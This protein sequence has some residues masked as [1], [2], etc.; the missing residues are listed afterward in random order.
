MKM[1]ISGGPAQS[2]STVIGTGG[3]WNRD[4]VIIVGNLYGPLNRISEAGGVATEITNVEISHGEIGHGLPSLLPDGKHFLYFIRGSPEVEGVYAGSL[5][6]KPGEQPRKQI[7]ASLLAAS[8]ANGYLFFMRDNT[9]M[10]QAFDPRAL[11]LQGEPVSLAENV[12]TLLNSGVFSVSPSGVL[13]YHSVTHSGGS[14]FT[15][16]D[17][18][19]RESG[20]LGDRT[21]DTGPVLSPDG[22]RV[23]VRDSDA[24][25]SADLWILDIKRRGMR[26]RV[27]TRQGII[28]PAVWSADGTHVIFAAGNKADG[29][30]ASNVIYEKAS[31]GAVDEKELFRDTKQNMV[32]TSWS[33]DGRF[34]LYHTGAQT[35]SD[36]LW[37]LPLEGDR[38]PVQLL[39]TKS[40]ERSASFSPDG[41]WIAYKSDETGRWEIYVRPFVASGP[42]GAPSL[43]ERRWQISKD[44]AAHLRTDLAAGFPSWRA[45]GKEILFGGPNGAVMAVD[46][47]T[48]GGAHQPFGVPKKLFTMQPNAGPWAVTSDGKKFLAP[49]AHATDG[50]TPITVVLN[51]RAE[52]NR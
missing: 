35:H 10:A 16:F 33:R 47:N 34:L 21:S 38:K 7:L 13:A 46:V 32:P 49:V 26:T 48:S 22:T 50:P 24:Y 45:D 2:L 15:W 1:D 43:G 12:D 28:R 9:L 52:L 29:N 44:G 27:T 25:H 6:A 31:T 11:E 37:V 19:G 14:Q 51:W 40:N 4:G 39:A 30:V 42:S 3:A 23:A 36:D 41:R 20:V 8:Y 17:R 5:D 18:Q